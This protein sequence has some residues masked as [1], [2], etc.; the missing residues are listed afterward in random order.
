MSADQNDLR[1]L[2]V[3]LDTGV[4][5]IPLL[6]PAR[7][8]VLPYEPF[9]V[10]EL[11][12]PLRGFV[13]S[14]AESLHCDPVFVAL[15]LLVALASAI[16]NAR[17]VEIK[18][19][20]AEPCILW[21]AIIG[22]SGTG[23]SPGLDRAI[24]FAY[25][26]DRLAQRGFRD[27]QK[28]FEAAK[29]D[30]ER[31]CCRWRRSK[32]NEPPPSQPNPPPEARHVVNDTTVEAV[33]SQLASS[34][35]GLLLV[36]DELSAWFG[37]F[38]QYKQG[39][40]QAEEAQWIEMFGGRPVRVDRKSSGASLYAPRA[41]VSVAG[42]LQPIALLKCLNQD[43]IGSGMA[44]R[45]LLVMP[46]EQPQ[47]WSDTSVDPALTEGVRD[48]FR[49]LYGL[50]GQS[51]TVEDGLTPIDI[52]LS[53]GA[54][55]LFIEFHD[56]LRREQPDLDDARNAAWSKFIS[57]APRIGLILHC[58]K[59][60][61]SPSWP[62]DQPLT[63]TTMAAAL[64]ITRWLQQEAHRVYDYLGEDSATRRLR[65]AMET[66][67]RHQGR[68]T[69]RD[70]Q[71]AHPVEFPTAERAKTAL[72]ELVQ[73]GIGIWERTAP[74]PA[75][76]RPSDVFVLLQPRDTTDRTSAGGGSVGSVNGAPGPREPWS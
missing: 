32:G 25:E 71:R 12:D 19:D 7:I 59:D 55:V 10:H 2:G 44:A 14:S 41:S 17:R 15:P 61:V 64:T 37:S 46:P 42:G 21:A 72:E 22:R 47:L 3:D 9:P 73:Q 6:R 51:E 69:A 40:G 1:K 24:R 75:G 53:D 66:A 20:W 38:G 76:G 52:R 4:T 43:R 68:T 34:P 65:R 67:H 28:Q 74:S 29:Q 54:R 45:F 57:V 70:L 5:R 39:H 35:R 50:T 31:E 8:R 62:P 18:P 48:V 49:R 23:K 11:P 26:Q 36:R 27:K 60:A 63:E 58:V 30:Y 13:V 16:G 56:A 33:V